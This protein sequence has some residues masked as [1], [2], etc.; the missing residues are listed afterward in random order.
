[1]LRSV[2]LRFPLFIHPP[3]DLAVE[4][5]EKTHARRLY[6]PILYTHTHTVGGEGCTRTTWYIYTRRRWRAPC[7]R[8]T[9]NIFAGQKTAAED[10][11]RCEHPSS[12]SRHCR[13]VQD[14][15]LHRPGRTARSHWP[16]SRTVTPGPHLPAT[17]L[18]YTSFV[19]T[20]RDYPL[21]GY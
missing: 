15:Q 9:D 20:A 11:R 16:G 3:F 5:R 7:C 13:R 2:F 17:T 10:L 4:Y 18:T 12:S 8:K 6:A 14:Q 21:G 1:M 19:V